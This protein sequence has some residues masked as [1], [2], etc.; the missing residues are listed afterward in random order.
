MNGKLSIYTQCLN[1]E[2]CCVVGDRLMTPCSD[3]CC[4]LREVQAAMQMSHSWEESLSL[5]KTLSHICC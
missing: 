1:E 2:I 4:A 5:V 3:C